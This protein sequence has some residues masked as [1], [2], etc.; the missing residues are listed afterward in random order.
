METLVPQSMQSSQ[1]LQEYRK[2]CFILGQWV[3]VVQSELSYR[4]KAIDIGSD[5]ALL[6]EIADGARRRLQTGEVSIRK[7]VTV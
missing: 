7:V 1:F 4:A 2:R 5:G 3:Q 6:V